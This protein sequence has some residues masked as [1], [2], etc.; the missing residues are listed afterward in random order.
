L[1]ARERRLEALVGESNMRRILELTSLDALLGVSG[2]RA[3]YLMECLP[4]PQG[5]QT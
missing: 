3:R 1:T 4:R 5:S 2:E